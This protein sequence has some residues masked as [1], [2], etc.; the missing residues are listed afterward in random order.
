MYTP[1]IGSN[2]CDETIWKLRHTAANSAVR[3]HHAT[4]QRH[5]SYSPES[6]FLTSLQNYTSQEISNKPASSAS[7]FSSMTRF[8]AGRKSVALECRGGDTPPNRVAV[9]HTSYPPSSQRIKLSTRYSEIKT[10]SPDL[11]RNNTVQS[12]FDW[13]TSEHRRQLITPLL[14]A[15]RTM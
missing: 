6:R 15:A 7:E 13:F 14:Y 1:A 10:N 12:K 4:L 11:P 2:L 5:L 9:Q 8:M 3:N